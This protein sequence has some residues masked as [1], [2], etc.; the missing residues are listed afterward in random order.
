MTF[1]CWLLGFVVQGGVGGNNLLLSNILAAERP[2]EH[3]RTPVTL[4]EQHRPVL[5]LKWRMCRGERRE[6]HQRPHVSPDLPHR[7]APALAAVAA[8]LEKGQSV[9]T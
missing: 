8:M 3:L 9:K 7:Q 5:Y 6:N 4:I 2:K 1:W